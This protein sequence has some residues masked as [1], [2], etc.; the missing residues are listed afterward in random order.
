[1]QNRKNAHVKPL[2]IELS[3]KIAEIYS[4][5]CIYCHKNCVKSMYMLLNVSVNCFHKIFFYLAR[6]NFSIFHTVQNVGIS[7]FTFLNT[8]FT[9]IHICPSF[10]VM[11]PVAKLLMNAAIQY[12]SF[13]LLKFSQESEKH[14]QRRK[15][16]DSNATFYDIIITL[17][18][19]FSIIILQLLRAENTKMISFQ[20]GKK[21]SRH[22]RKPFISYIQG[23]EL[24]RQ[25]NKS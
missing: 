16:W 24:L 10:S 1:M 15:K 19:F 9:K 20:L 12:L 7:I 17:S 21:R 13:A 18:K 25:G 4:P 5:L 6:V 2:C 22:L 23:Y 14:S 8:I 11:C 3:V